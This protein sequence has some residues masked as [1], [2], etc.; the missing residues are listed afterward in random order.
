[1]GDCISALYAEGIHCEGVFEEPFFLRESRRRIYAAA[2]RSD[3][4]LAT[5]FGRPPMMSWRYSDRKIP[6]DLDD[7]VVTTSDT[8]LLNNELAKLDSAGWNTEGKIFASSWIRARSQISVIKERLLEQSLAGRTDSDVTEKLQSISADCR[9]M[10]ESFPAHLRYDLYDEDEAWSN[11]DPSITLRMISFYLEFLH[12]EFQVH[13]IMRRQTQLAVPALLELSMRLL[14]TVLVFNKQRS[15]A[16]SIQRHFP[17]IILFYC[18][19]SAGVL[20]L[21]L[22]RSTLQNVP[23]PGALSRADV[24]RNLSVL[25]SCLEWVIL[26][27]DGNHNLC[28]ELNKMLALV[29]DEVLNYQPPAASE[30]QD[31]GDGGALGTVGGGFFDMPLIE[32]MEPIPTESED[33]L[34]WLDNANWGNTASLAVGSC[35]DGR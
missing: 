15:Q 9:A 28:S 26:P 20:A 10:W 19:P 23:L 24:I 7:E 27:G 6:L 12:M 13:R 8:T 1:M 2:Y 32:G 30:S 22:R 5:F 14:S 4:T 25:I 34:N 18:L 3:K 35:F 17:T 33:F 21:E 31:G 11:L 29:L 16:Y